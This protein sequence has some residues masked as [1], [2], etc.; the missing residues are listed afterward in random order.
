MRGKGLSMS[1]VLNKQAIKNVLKRP[2]EL[3]E[4]LMRQCCY[5]ALEHDKRCLQKVIA[6]SKRPGT[7]KQEKFGKRGP[8]HIWKMCP[9]VAEELTRI[10]R[11]L[12]EAIEKKETWITKVDK[13]GRVDRLL[14]IKTLA[15]ALA[16]AARDEERRRRARLVRQDAAAGNDPRDVKVVRRCEDGFV[17]VQLKTPAALK[18]EG[19]H[20]RHCL[21]NITYAKRLE[22]GCSYFSIRNPEGLSR[23]TLEV[24]QGRVTQCRGRANSDPFP[25][26]GHRIEA[27]A[28]CFGWECPDALRPEQPQLLSTLE[29][30]RM[31][32][33]HPLRLSVDL[34]PLPRTLYVN[35]T[36]EAT[37]LDELTTLPVVMNVRGDLIIRK[38]RNLRFMPQ[39]LRVGGNAIIEDCSV[40]RR[41]GT[42]F[43]AGGTLS[44][45]HCPKLC[46]NPARITIGESLVV[47]QCPKVGRPPSRWASS[48][49]A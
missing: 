40:L 19:V 14:K 21:G 36:F 23:V 37:S 34:I 43:H 18:W 31:V 8:D 3:H 25:K 41:L 4:K 2:N 11:W 24:V 15:E 46:L 44:L 26:Y 48:L 45:R 20:M 17:A 35:G 27:L 7:D 39:W 5:R 12:W 13:D 10:D 47:H 32:V 22:A 42:N 9:E 29:L 30:H 1:R 49:R 33:E 38:C 6:S 28:D 16:L